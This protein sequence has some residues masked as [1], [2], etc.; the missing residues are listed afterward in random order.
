M[1]NKIN[2]NDR[3]DLTLNS[4]LNPKKSEQDASIQ[5]I[6]EQSLKNDP[7][8][9]S[10]S[11]KKTVRIEIETS[12]SKK[13]QEVWY[14]RVLNEVSKDTYSA[15]YGSEDYPWNRIKNVCAE[16]EKL[17]REFTGDTAQIF[18]SRNPEE[19]HPYYRN[20][21]MP[22]VAL[23][24]SYLKEKHRLDH[25]YVCDSL[26][27]FQLKLDEISS[28]TTDIRASIII[29]SNFKARED[30]SQKYLGNAEEKIVVCIEKKSD[31]IKIAIL[32]STEYEDAID[33]SV[34][35]APVE[36]FKNDTPNSMNSV[37]WYIYH[38]KLDVTKSEIYYS[39]SG[40]QG[41]DEIQSAAFSLRNAVSFLQYPQFFDHILHYQLSMKDKNAEISLRKITH[42]PLVFLKGVQSRSLLL[43]LTGQ[44]IEKM[45]VK[46]PLEDLESLYERIKKHAV[47]LYHRVANCYINQ[48]SHKYHLMALTAC[49]ILSSDEI[50]EILQKTLLTDSR[51]PAPN[52][53]RTPSD[54][55]LSMYNEVK[56]KSLL[57]EAEQNILSE[58]ATLLTEDNDVDDEDDD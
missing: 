19:E 14:K 38:S 33:L 1:V 55:K 8:T 24:A 40:F 15:P 18:Y 22:G 7:Q 52:A 36:H 58:I 2:E 23:I 35:N 21:G 51:S 16:G 39:Q 11:Q 9:P 48:R 13:S 20:L 29:P 42:L 53:P 50:E 43:R 25:L 4:G 56:S 31:S 10:N 30:G 28:S 5:N 12:A 37:L 26:E 41:E 32:D 44:Y 34:V 47:E 46:P 3:S 27:A 57:S 6:A 54:A 17:C 49:K 45:Q